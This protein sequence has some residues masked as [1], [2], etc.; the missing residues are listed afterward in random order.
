MQDRCLVV[1]DQHRGH[2]VQCGPDVPVNAESATVGYALAVL[3]D[4]LDL[5]PEDIRRITGWD[6]K[7]EGACKGELCVPMP[8]LETRPDGTVDVRVFAKHMAMPL[9]TD[10]KHGVSALGPEG[11]GRVLD[12][13]A[14]P[15]IVLPDFGG[16]AFDVA[17]LR[18]RKVLLLAW[19]S[20]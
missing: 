19:A 5:T 14:L 4:R 13:V 6:I 18:G 3:L 7:A 20:W 2:G 8:D 16:K 10:D 17:S 12:D 9:V 11:G 15:E 1:D